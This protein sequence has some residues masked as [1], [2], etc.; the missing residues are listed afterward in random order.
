MVNPPAPL[1]KVKYSSSQSKQNSPSTLYY[2]RPSALR[3]P[4]KDVQS[5]SWGGFSRNGS[6]S[7]TPVSARFGSTPFC[8]VK[9]SAYGDSFVGTLTLLKKSAVRTIKF[10]G[11]SAKGLNN[12]NS[13]LKAQSSLLNKLDRFMDENVLLVFG[14]VDLQLNYYW[15]IA[16]GSTISPKEFAEEVVDNYLS[17]IKEHMLPRI[18]REDDDSERTFK[19]S[20]GISV[21]PF[22]KK[23][24]ISCAFYPTI[25]DEHYLDGFWKYT[26][27]QETTIN[28]DIRL[29]IPLETFEPR[30]DMTEIF[31]KAVKEFCEKENCFF[32]DV[33][34]HVLD[35]SRKR[36][37]IAYRDSSD[38]TNIHVLWERTLPYWIKELSSTG[39]TLDDVDGNLDDLEKTQ[40]AYLESKAERVSKRDFT[41]GS[42]S[43]ERN[44]RQIVEGFNVRGR[45][46]G[47]ASPVT[48]S[49]TRKEIVEN[50]TAEWRSPS[51][52]AKSPSAEKSTFP[53]NDLNITSPHADISP[54][55]I[56]IPEKPSGN[57][58][59]LSAVDRSWKMPESPSRRQPSLGSAVASPTRTK[60]PS[61][62]QINAAALDAAIKAAQD[63]EP[64]R[65]MSPIDSNWKTKT[66]TTESARGRS[67]SIS[68]LK[69][70]T[71]RE[72]SWGDNIADP[73]IEL[74]MADKE[75]LEMLQKNRRQSKFNKS[76]QPRSNDNSEEN[77]DSTDDIAELVL[78]CLPNLKL[79]EV[80]SD[81]WL[82]GDI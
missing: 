47:E 31:N 26:R 70:A 50:K 33:N 9:L 58:G 10:K 32:V 65:P 16:N 75:L 21:K 20:N 35:S 46:D 67:R 8:P 23:L 64:I 1:Q 25:E 30:W 82:N 53:R 66:P 39:I 77:G 3:R 71:V 80:R 29:L 6:I 28:Q 11:A 55:S 37:D 38:P 81:P 42:T 45:E 41:L 74:E 57:D 5:P 12:P 63:E 40:K 48:S 69:S 76:T 44:S 36:I 68:P 14:T 7:G 43:E 19:N 72:S 49:P 24:F 18:A 34:A 62:L 61:R 73:N 2:N 27:K 4:S 15:K 60:S 54:L 78:K 13:T 59:P 56:K 79:D 17:F 22:I 52:A 51:V